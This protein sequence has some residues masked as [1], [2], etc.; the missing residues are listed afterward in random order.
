[1]QPPSNYLKKI[2]GLTEGE[3][4]FL[5]RRPNVPY[6]PVLHKFYPLN[7]GLSKR[8]YGTPV[9]TL[10]FQEN[11][12]FNI[13]FKSSEFKKSAESITK[14][15]FD[16][17]SGEKHIKKTV[18]KCKKAIKEA[19]KI[20]KKNLSLYSDQ[21][22]LDASNKITSAYGES[23]V[24]GYVTWASKILADHALSILKSKNKELKKLG[25][26][27]KSAFGILAISP[28]LSAYNKKENALNKLVKAYQ[29]KVKTLA[30]FEEIK[31]KFPDLDLK[32]NKFLDSYEWVAYD[33]CGPAISYSDVAKEIC[34]REIK[35]KEKGVTKKEIIKACKLKKKE[36]QLFYMFSLLALI[37]DFRNNAD[38]IVHFSLDFLYAEISKRKGMRRDDLRQL[39]PEEFVQLLTEKKE[40]SH[41][42][43]TQKN[44]LSL[45]EISE[46][47]AKQFVGSEAKIELSK[48]LSFS[49]TKIEETSEFKGS[50]ASVGK[51]RG[52][53]RIIHNYNEVGKVNK[54]DIL[55]STM[56]SPQYMSG[57]IR[58]SALVTDDGGLTCHAAI[59]ARELKKPCIVGT[60][61][62][63]RTLKDGD[64]IEV[65]ANKG[66][67]RKISK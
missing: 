23:F 34:D 14:M 42:Y 3:W 13:Y 63:T 67:V 9:T 56:T 10:V 11:G 48:R 53:A 22:L 20:Y 61:I 47:N 25:L 31:T 41:E 7:K 30:S 58:A 37:K 66:L 40:F 26:N 39:W 19:R 59:I 27:E 15:L 50:I 17:N 16:F 29:E 4:H 57:I 54:G 35:P 43:L 24:F 21:E 55:V 1:M 2:N 46:N 33:Y 49:A 12:F 65:D 18:S 44:I 60:K 64:L 52:I 5:A 32:I 62:A 45:I 36:Q 28:K 51:V 8:L 38:D 6:L